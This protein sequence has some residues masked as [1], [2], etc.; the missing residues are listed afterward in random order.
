M[1]RGLRVRVLRGGGRT[2]LRL[3]AGRIALNPR[4]NR[5]KPVDL[6]KRFRAIAHPAEAKIT[7][8]PPKLSAKQDQPREGA[9]GGFIDFAHIDDHRLIPPQT[10]GGVDDSA[11]LTVSEEA[12]LRRYRFFWHTH[13]AQLPRDQ[14][15]ALQILSPQTGS[16]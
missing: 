13:G 14:L 7:P 16:G 11:C 5:I 2:R 3:P 6:V 12:V 1:R 8:F 15:I 10:H 4:K 9:G